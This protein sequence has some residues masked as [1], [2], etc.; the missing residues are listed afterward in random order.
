MLAATKVGG[1]AL[2]QDE[3]ISSGLNKR[4][5]ESNHTFCY[6]EAKLNGKLTVFLRDIAT[7]SKWLRLWLQAGTRSKWVQP[8][9]HYYYLDSHS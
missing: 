5:V 2:G 1:F 9:E 8:G 7:A 3:Q 4:S 6:I